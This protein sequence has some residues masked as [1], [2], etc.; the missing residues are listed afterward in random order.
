MGE[1]LNLGQEK[2]KKA[3][4]PNDWTPTELL[5]SMSSESIPRGVFVAWIDELGQVQVRRSQLDEG[6]EV[7]IIRTAGKLL[8]GDLK[9]VGS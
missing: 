5:S 1:L 9:E 8:L 3:Q 2:R 6:D 7:R 4:S